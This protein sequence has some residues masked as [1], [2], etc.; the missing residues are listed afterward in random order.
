MA[1]TMFPTAALQGLI[2]SIHFLGVT[3]L[4][5]FFSRRL[6]GDG[7]NSRQ[8]WSRLTW[9]RIC[10]LLVFLDSYLFLFSSGILVFGVGLQ[11]NGTACAAGIYLCVLFYTSSKILIYSF[12]TEKVYIVWDTGRSRLRSSVFLIC[13]GTLVLYGAVIIAVIVGHIAQFRQGDGACVIGLK[14]T[15]SL[16]LLSYD[17]FINFLLTTLFLWPLLRSRHANPKLRRLAIRT[18]VAAGMALT[19]STVNIAVLTIMKGRQLGWLCLA[20]CGIDVIFNAAALFWVTVGANSQNSLSSSS[21]NRHLSEIPMPST[22]LALSVPP[23]PARSAFKQDID[24]KG[25]NMFKMGPL[26]PRAKEFQIHVTTQSH[27]TTSPPDPTS[28][29]ETSTPSLCETPSLHS[30]TDSK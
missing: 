7:L 15:A 22:T 18:L 10:V 1:F 24:V 2:A 8:A 21:P 3:I 17:L 23:S 16:P 25:A 12:L 4:T 19:T 20:S 11:L 26:S 29:S 30:E 27:I 14:P 28:L 13:M 5:F 6:L 9:P